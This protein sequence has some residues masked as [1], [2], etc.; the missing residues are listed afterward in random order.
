M[1]Y[2]RIFIVVLHISTGVIAAPHWAITKKVIAPRASS[3]SVFAASLCG[4]PCTVSFDALTTTLTLTPPAATVSV[5]DSIN[6][7]T[8]N[9]DVV[10][11][12]TVIQPDAQT[13]ANGDPSGTPSITLSSLSLNPFSVQATDTYTN[14]DG[15]QQQVVVDQDVDMDEFPALLD[16][17]EASDECPIQHAARNT[18][19]QTGYDTKISM[20]PCK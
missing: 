2:M 8:V 13:F 15:Q 3:S 17:D 16:D 14:T 6:S 18:A 9:F 20:K 4:S 1:F 10:T 12:E 5:S 11:T 7:V 19:P